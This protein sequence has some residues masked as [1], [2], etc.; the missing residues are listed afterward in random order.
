M[1]MGGES[2]ATAYKS[3]LTR[4]PAGD[5]LRCWRGD[6]AGEA[7]GLGLVTHKPKVSLRAK[8]CC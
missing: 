1:L 6:A 7:I 5:A 4:R 8:S 2:P 3:G